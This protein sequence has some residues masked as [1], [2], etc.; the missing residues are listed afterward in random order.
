M[1]FVVGL[2]SE[3]AAESSRIVATNER[4]R[5]PVAAPSA[6]HN[7]ENTP[8]CEQISGYVSLIQIEKSKEKMLYTELVPS[9]FASHT[10]CPSFWKRE[11]HPLRGHI[12][13]FDQ[14]QTI[15]GTLAAVFRSGDW[16]RRP[17]CSPDPYP[18]MPTL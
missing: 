6:N 18:A 7:I 13:R 2:F 14:D 8:L 16:T 12:A 1:G 5:K 4:Y 15:P 17:L 9:S 3:S 10:I 11:R